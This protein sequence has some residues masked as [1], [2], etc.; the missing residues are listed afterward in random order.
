M[1][2]E[3][4]KNDVLESLKAACQAGVN[5][6]RLLA[7]YGLAADTPARILQ[8]GWLHPE[9][10]DL[11]EAWKEF[12]NKRKAWCWTLKRYHAERGRE[13]PEQVN[14]LFSEFVGRLE[15]V[16]N[17][18]NLQASVRNVVDLVNQL[19]TDDEQMEFDF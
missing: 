6:A 16:F 14:I 18:E 4:K 9:C 7:R 19:V 17:E 10:V 5:K 1:M 3:Y 15:S 12:W 13:V 2:K 8:G 11:N